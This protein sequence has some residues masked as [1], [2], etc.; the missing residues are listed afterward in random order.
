MSQAA[1]CIPLIQSRLPPAGLPGL[2]SRPWIP[3]LNAAMGRGPS[4]PHEDRFPLEWILMAP[5]TT[6]FLA[7]LGKPLAIA[8]DL[9]ASPGVWWL[10]TAD[11]QHEYIVFSDGHRKNSWKGGQVCMASSDPSPLNAEHP[12]VVALQR[13][14]EH[15]WGLPQVSLVGAAPNMMQ[16]L[17]WFGERTAQDGPFE[18]PRSH[19]S[20]KRA[21][22]P[23]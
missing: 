12:G 21:M 17:L 20:H 13:G 7:S 18:W 14:F 6:E 3:L 19:V 9:E 15:V 10:A 4:I 1:S 16:A 8:H 2:L 11:G 22:S 23:R 5:N